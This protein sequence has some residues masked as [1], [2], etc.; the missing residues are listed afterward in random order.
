MSGARE[1]CFNRTG[2][3]ASAILTDRD[4]HAAGAVADALVEERFYSILFPAAEPS[5]AEEAREAPEYFRDL[6]LDQL[7]GAIAANCKDHDLAP[8][9]HRPLRD[10]ATIVYRQQVMR[11][12]EQPAVLQAIKSFSH[13]MATI[14]QH[15]ERS[16]KSHYRHDKLRWFLGAAEI[17]SETVTQLRD[18]LTQANLASQG[19]RSLRNY[20]VAYAES[21]TFTDMAAEA[22]RIVSQLAA[23]RYAILVKDNGVTVR[24]YGGEVDYTPLVE[25]TFEKFR[26]GAVKDYRA[27]FPD[28]EGMN[29]IQ[30]QIVDRVALLYPDAFHALDAFC[31]QHAEFAES[32]IWCLDREIQFYVAYLAHIAKFRAAG[33]VFCYPEVSPSS[34][35]VSCRDAFDLALADKLL[36]KKRS[37]VCNDFFLRGAERLFVVSGP[38]QGGKTTFARMFG[39]LHYLAALGC[40]IPGTEAQLFLFDRLFAHFEREE[41]ITNLRG[42]LKDDLVRIKRVLDQATPNSIVIM[43]EIFSSTT[44]EDQIF[45]SRKVMARIVELDLPAVCVTFLTELASISANTVSI[46][47][48]IDPN[49]P[50]VRTFRLERRPADGLAYALAV[51]RKH[52]VTYECLKER[53]RS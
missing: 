24:R 28:S 36:A 4:A 25:A 49:D 34:K 5:T 29:H 7:V 32:R 50:A 43:N 9:F 31:A 20:L 13:G 21:A 8:F 11:D 14:R 53:I 48:T 22:A 52:R 17:Y 6:N 47:S 30:A 38:N 18:E 12:V 35:G 46:V 37:V 45:L 1:E 27:K 3:Q 42:K 44:L 2:D 10:V 23:I 33:L 16:T 39:Q 19:M 51:A 26:R 15:F 40:L 41:D